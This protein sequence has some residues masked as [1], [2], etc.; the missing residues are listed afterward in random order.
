MES[1]KGE[2]KDEKEEERE[3]SQTWERLG[4]KERKWEGSGGG[5]W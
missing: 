2:E 5:G 1:V 3:K 4:M